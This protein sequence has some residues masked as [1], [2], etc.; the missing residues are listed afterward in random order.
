M[1]GELE[2]RIAALGLGARV[3]LPGAQPREVVRELLRQ[4]D[5]FVLPSRSEGMP[6]SLLEAMACGLP[7]VV[8]DV[9][10][11]ARTGGEAIRLV[12]REDPA[13]LARS[14]IELAGDAPMRRRLSLAAHARAAEHSSESAL[15]AHEDFLLGTLGPRPVPSLRPSGRAG[16][17]GRR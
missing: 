8:C 12:P 16:Q 9:G 14:V 1:R 5:L 2:A 6:L 15:A 13:A 3:R 7:S 17:P 10:G 11:V 4:S